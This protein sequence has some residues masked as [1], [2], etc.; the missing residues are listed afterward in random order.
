[1]LMIVRYE[2]VGV[3]K[4]SPKENFENHSFCVE[5]QF[6]SINMASSL[7][8]ITFLDELDFPYIQTIWGI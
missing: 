8:F 5:T 2:Q 1:M 6:V 7:V 4:S 3:W